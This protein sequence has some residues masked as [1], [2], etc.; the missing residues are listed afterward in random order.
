MLPAARGAGPGSP[1]LLA[2]W[3]ATTFGM[4]LDWWLERDE[5]LPASAAEHEFR[6]LI[7]PALA[8]RLG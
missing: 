1:Q 2:R 5:P 6:R 8:E 4:V 7:E 3:I